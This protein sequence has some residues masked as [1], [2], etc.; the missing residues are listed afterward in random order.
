VTRRSETSRSR[1]T[2]SERGGRPAPTP[3]DVAAH[4]L[5]RRPLTTTELEARL[6]AKGYQARTASGVV[7]RALELHWLDDEMLAH[8]RARSLR[9]RG[10]GPLRITADLEGRGLP[11]ALIEAAVE[12][13]RD[14]REEADWAALALREAGI[15]S[16]GEPARAWRLLLQRGFPEDVVARL[17]DVE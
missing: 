2:G 13:S 16:G 8:D 9:G 3:L 10:S 7:A 14:G 12:A 17:L 1:S 5:A 6:V 15:T 4:L 11:A